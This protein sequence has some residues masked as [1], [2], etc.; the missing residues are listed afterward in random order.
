[1]FLPEA[2]QASFLQS[3]DVEDG[4]KDIE[5]SKEEERIKRE[6]EIFTESLLSAYSQQPD[7]GQLFNELMEARCQT[8]SQFKRIYCHCS[9]EPNRIH[10]LSIRAML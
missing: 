6:T 9:A 2:F 7:V 4:A 3:C 10:L 5:A 1:M 8:F